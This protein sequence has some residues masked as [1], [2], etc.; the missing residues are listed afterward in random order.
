[1]GTHYSPREMMDKL[2]AFPTVSDVSNL[3]LISFVQDYLSGHGIESQ[4]TYN[5]H[6]D[7]ANLHALVGPNEPGGIILSGH[8]DVVPIEGQDWTSDPWTVTERDGKL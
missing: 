8:T 4:L 3:D 6:G 5:E 1:M 7:K 2:V